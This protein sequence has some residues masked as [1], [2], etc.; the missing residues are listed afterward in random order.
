MSFTSTIN[1]TYTGPI[2]LTTPVSPLYIHWSQ[3]AGT[4]VIENNS[5]LIERA[6]GPAFGMTYSSV[7]TGLSNLLPGD[8]IGQYDYSN[9]SWD[10]TTLMLDWSGTLSVVPMPSSVLAVPGLAAWLALSR[11][12]RQR[13]L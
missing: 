8:E 6:G 12:S 10:G 2:D 13:M 4:D 5:G 1:G 3:G 9:V 11:R 7:F